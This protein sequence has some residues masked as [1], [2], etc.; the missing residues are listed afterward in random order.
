MQ[1]KVKDLMISVLPEHEEAAGIIVPCPAC[2]RC[3]NCTR[4]TVGCSPRTDCQGCTGCSLCTDSQPPCGYCTGACTHCSHACTG[5]TNNL[6]LPDPASLEAEQLAVLKAQ[7]QHAL[8]LVH[9]QENALE[10]RLK[11][12]SLTDVNLLEQKL[13]EALGE[14]RSKKAEMLGSAGKPAGDNP[15]QES[16]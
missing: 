3:T 13:V 11:P 5:Y 2:S 7:L 8:T 10:Q 9:A 6:I 15:E 14:V 12:Q 4:C 1:F 16:S